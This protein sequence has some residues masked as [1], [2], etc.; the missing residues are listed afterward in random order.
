MDP[1]LT[2]L[3][4]RVAAETRRHFDVVVGEV[5]AEVVET[6]RHSEDVAAE[7]RRHFDVVAESLRSEV[8]LVAERVSALGERFE[9]FRLEVKEEFAEVRAMIRLSYAELD[10][11]LRALE[12][13]YSALES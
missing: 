7:T 1:A 8:R 13:G 12:S 3:A 11:R 4:E 5:R 6:R 10:R 9:R 2:E